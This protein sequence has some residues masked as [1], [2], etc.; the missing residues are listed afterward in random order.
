MYCNDDYTIIE[1]RIVFM[2]KALINLS[3]KT[4]KKKK[5][6]KCSRRQGITNVIFLIPLN[7]FVSIFLTLVNGTE[8]HVN[9]ISFRYNYLSNQNSFRRL[10]A[11]ERYRN[12]NRVNERSRLLARGES[13]L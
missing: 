8:L 3:S 1:Q 2:W 9:G 10:T 12:K 13:N 5:K 4:K 6:R 7:L 11:K